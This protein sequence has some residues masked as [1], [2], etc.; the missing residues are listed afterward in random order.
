MSN[1]RLTLAANESLQLQDLISETIRPSGIELTFLD[2]AIEENNARFMSFHE[3]EVSEAS[4][5]NFCASLSQDNP[6]A[7][8]L[9]VFTSRVFRHSALYVRE[10]SDIKSPSDLK[11]RKVGIPQWSQT[12]TIYVRGYLSHDC[13]VPLESV[14]WIQAGINDPGRQE[15]AQIQLPPGI[16]LSSRPDRALGEMLSKGELDAIISARPPKMFSAGGFGLC[17]LFPNYQEEEERYFKKT[18]IFPIMHL[19]VLRRD[20]YEANRWIARSL[21][22]AFDASKR[23]ALRKLDDQGY[24]YIPS[25]WGQHQ[26]ARENGMLFGKNDPWPYGVEANRKT[27]EAFVTYCHEQGVTKRHLSI[28]ELFPKELGIKIRI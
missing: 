25:A 9:P 26:I 15:T 16:R 18:G 12:A 10:G 23:S 13:G 1:L 7:I 24:S 2:M 17:R 8:A 11:G 28:D 21:F 22:E 6:L 27:L 4:F 14:E 3:W 5:G 20:S 19:V